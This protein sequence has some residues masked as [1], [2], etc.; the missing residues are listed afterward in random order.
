[1]VDGTDVKNPPI[2]SID[3][4]FPKKLVNKM[5]QAHM[6]KRYKKSSST[7][8]CRSKDNTTIPFK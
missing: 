2:T 6:N 3:I 1:M 5:V 8:G 4:I 7:S